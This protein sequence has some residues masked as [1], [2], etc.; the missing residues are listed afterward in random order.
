[1][2]TDAATTQFIYETMNSSPGS[3]LNTESISKTSIITV[4]VILPI[5]LFLLVAI[6]VII[7]ALIITKVVHRKSIVTTQV[8]A[9][10]NRV[11]L[12]TDHSND[13]N[14]I[15]T[16]V[17]VAYHQHSKEDAESENSYEYIQ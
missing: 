10:Y 7:I 12:N 14:G 8:N 5:V 3:T 4:S 13:G 15:I 11:T 9:A 16:S 17:N 2:C 1:M 6:I